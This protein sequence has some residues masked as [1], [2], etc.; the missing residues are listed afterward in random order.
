MTKPTLNFFALLSVAV[1]VYVNAAA[2]DT[3]VVASTPPATASELEAVY[4]T[5][6]EIRTDDILKAL[7]L[8][9]AA[10]SNRVHDI[11]IAHYRAL[12]TR[13]AIIDAR[14]KLIGKPINYANRAPDL[15]IASKPLHKQFLAQLATVL[16]PAQIDTVKDKMTYD[17]VKF[18]YDAYCAIVP[19]LTDADK[20]KILELL[21]AAREE[22]MDGGNAPEKSAIFQKYKD[23]INAYLN[24]HGHDVAQAY[25]VWNVKHPGERDTNVAPSTAPAK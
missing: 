17:K 11:I 23:Q 21:K 6:I 18:T 7:A 9:D 4:N 20:A 1:L 8:N 14:L 12:R 13:D 24:A 10:K 16:T 25:R 19:G 22:A 2:A 15:E 3:R 5:A